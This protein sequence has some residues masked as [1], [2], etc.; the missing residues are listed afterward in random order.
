MAQK[1]LYSYGY[2]RIYRI[3]GHRLHI[4]LFTKTAA[5]LVIQYIPTMNA[6]R[7]EERD[8]IKQE[9]VKRISL[10]TEYHFA[11]IW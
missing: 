3:T 9:K 2:I 5:Q 1:K 6:T 10:C 4:Y 11:R 7:R 8:I